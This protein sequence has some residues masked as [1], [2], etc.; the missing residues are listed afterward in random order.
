M[1]TLNAIPVDI[2]VYHNSQRSF[3]LFETN[4]DWVLLTMLEVGYKAL[5]LDSATKNVIST[6][7]V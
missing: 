7:V 4:H 1:I 6:I 3:Y 2:R 5:L